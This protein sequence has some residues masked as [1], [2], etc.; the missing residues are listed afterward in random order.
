VTGCLQDDSFDKLLEVYCGLLGLDK[1]LIS[2]KVDG[3]PVGGK[4]NETPRDFAMADGDVVAVTLLVPSLPLGSSSSSSSIP[5][6]DEEGEATVSLTVQDKDKNKK[7]FK[8]AR[9]SRSHLPYVVFK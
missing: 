1:S 7:K 5:I 9:V 6:E 8:L 3:I 4:G 2:L